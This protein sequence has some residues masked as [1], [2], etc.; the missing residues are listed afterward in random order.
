M[1]IFSTAD[2]F[3]EKGRSR[4]N[5]HCR[6]Y[7]GTQATGRSEGWVLSFL[8]SLVIIKQEK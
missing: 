3:I 1:L 5:F 2:E 7:K 8:C 6:K 4:S